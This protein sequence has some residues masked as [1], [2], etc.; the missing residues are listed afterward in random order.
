MLEAT[1]AARS[2]EG[3][4]HTAEHN[5]VNTT[6]TKDTGHIAHGSKRAIICLCVTTPAQRINAVRWLRR[7]QCFRDVTV[8]SYR[9]HDA[10]LPWD[11]YDRGRRPHATTHSVRHR[12]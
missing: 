1:R 12:A 9:C 6:T 8:H 4:L 5:A 7:A 11:G 2:P 10:D 3:R